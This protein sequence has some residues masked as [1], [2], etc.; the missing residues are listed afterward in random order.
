MARPDVD[1]EQDVNRVFNKYPPLAHDRSR[2]TVTIEDGV[3]T[4]SGHV[5]TAQARDVFVR[6]VKKI[7]GVKAVHTDKL[8]N[9]DSLRI[10]TGQVTP[11]GVYTSVSYGAVVLTGTVPEGKTADEIVAAVKKIDGVRKVITNFR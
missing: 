11:F 6:E 10:E 9:D 1:I 7:E 2:M 3:V 8:Y 4:A 5:K